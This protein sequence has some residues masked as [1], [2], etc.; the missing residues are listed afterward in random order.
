MAKFDISG[1]ALDVRSQAKELMAQLRA[2]D[3][4]AARVFIEH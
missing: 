1:K 2:N 4:A 3:D